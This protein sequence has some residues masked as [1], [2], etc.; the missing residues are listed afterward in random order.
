MEEGEGRCV[1]EGEGRGSA[2]AGGGGEGQCHSGRGTCDVMQKVLC[3]VQ[4]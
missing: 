1:E 3:V 4:S 2:T